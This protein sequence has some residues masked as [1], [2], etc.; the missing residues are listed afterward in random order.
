M[1]GDCRVLLCLT[2]CTGSGRASVCSRLPQC[3]IPHKP[4]VHCPAL[5]SSDALTT[6]AGQALCWYGATGFIRERKPGGDALPAAMD[7][8]GY[9][10]GGILFANGAWHGYGAWHHLRGAALRAV[11]FMGGETVW[12]IP[13][14]AGSWDR[15]NC[16]PYGF[17]MGIHGVPTASITHPHTRLQG[18]AN[19]SN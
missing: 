7:R 3:I 9:A 15:Q 10:T 1:V 18:P 12:A 4:E 19:P 6:H 13:V 16:N 14:R 11:L 17:T 8:Q 5:G 2:K